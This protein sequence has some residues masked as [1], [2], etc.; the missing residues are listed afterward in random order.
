MNTA[1]NK[2][3]SRC[4]SRLRL[5]L[6]LMTLVCLAASAA[7]IGCS[8]KIQASPDRS[9]PQESAS[10]CETPPRR[11]VQE[12]IRVAGSYRAQLEAPGVIACPTA[13][14]SGDCEIFDLSPEPE[15]SPESDPDRFKALV[16]DR[17]SVAVALHPQPRSS[18]V[19]AVGYSLPDGQRR[20]QYEI[21]LQS[22]SASLFALLDDHLYVRDCV[23]A[24]PG[25]SGALYPLQ[26][27][28]KTSRGPFA[29]QA[30]PG[31]P[32]DYGLNVYEGSEIRVA[33]GLWAF[34]SASGHEVIWMDF[35]GRRSVRHVRISDLS[36][37]INSAGA[38]PWLEENA[39]PAAGNF[40]FRKGDALHILYG[41]YEKPPADGKRWR[42]RLN[43][44]TGAFLGQDRVPACPSS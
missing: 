15:Y 20:R 31:D 43:L 17:L 23:G 32:Q 30:K 11:P 2:P 6:P 24:G 25:C 36:P 7:T 5:R 27:K 1:T 35:A 8:P 29:V 13:P 16:D 28:S 37:G 33:P 42:V 21:E 41:V 3:H 14:G 4:V 22:R 26:S 44:K 34:V 39:D 19:R 38:L 10:A 40:G 12:G 18:E 9:A